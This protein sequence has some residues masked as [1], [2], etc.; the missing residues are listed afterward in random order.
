MIASEIK[1]MGV[2]EKLILME[3]IWENLLNE[4]DGGIESPVWHEEILKDR[5]EKIKTGKAE[6]I[7][8]KEI[9]SKN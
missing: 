9:R 6:F 5:M 2:K 7:S 8:I 4:T 1:K 3:Q